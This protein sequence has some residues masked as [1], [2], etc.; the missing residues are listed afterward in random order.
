[1]RVMIAMRRGRKAYKALHQSINHAKTWGEAYP[2]PGHPRGVRRDR[3]PQGT[4]AELAGVCP[5]TLEN[6]TEEIS[7]TRPP[8]VKANGAKDVMQMKFLLASI[9]R[10]SEA[11]L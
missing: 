7:I 6:E 11:A 8:L 5:A 4:G 9:Y 10:L 1:M 2:Y 3:P